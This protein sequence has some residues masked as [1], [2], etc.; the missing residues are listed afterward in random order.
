MPALNFCMNKKME[1]KK[2]METKIVTI[3]FDLFFRRK[4]L[5]EYLK[6]ELVLPDYYGMNLDAMYDVLSIYPWEVTFFIKNAEVSVDRNS[7]YK[8]RFLQVLK[9]AEKV[10]PKIH[11][12]VDF[13]KEMC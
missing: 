13:G 12:E 5:H 8:N 6:T 7:T 10:N 11:L 9:A 3:D 1:E 2:F 4:Q